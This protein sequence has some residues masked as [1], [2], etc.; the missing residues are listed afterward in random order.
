MIYQVVTV[1]QC[2]IRSVTAFGRFRCGSG[3]AVTLPLLCRPQPVL[4]RTLAPGPLSLA[5]RHYPGVAP[6]AAPYPDVEP[7]ASI[8]APLRVG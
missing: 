3:L 6:T 1:G 5:N 4:A 8:P 2:S 7:A